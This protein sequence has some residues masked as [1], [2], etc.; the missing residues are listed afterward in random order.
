MKFVV[1]HQITQVPNSCSLGTEL[2]LD[3]LSELFLNLQLKIV[4][5][6][7]DE[8]SWG[9]VAKDRGS[10]KYN[11]ILARQKCISL[12]TH[13][14]TYTYVHI[15]Y[16]CVCCWL[17]FLF[18]YFLNGKNCDL[19]NADYTFKQFTVTTTTKHQATLYPKKQK[20]K[21]ARKTAVKNGWRIFFFFL[22]NSFLNRF[23]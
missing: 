6:C 21:H 15:I 18:Y 5:S 17:S 13:L 8:H 16:D 19:Q 4:L 2:H 22:V 9:L 12:Y 23:F 7:G 20:T 14:N 11:S 1:K 10:S 3:S